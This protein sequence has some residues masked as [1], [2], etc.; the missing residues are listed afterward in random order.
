MTKK[1]IPQIGNN[2][3]IK[4]FDAST[5][6]LHRVIHVEGEIISQPICTD[7]ELYVTVKRGQHTSMKFYTVPN[8]SLKKTQS[9][10]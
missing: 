3:T 2:N 10:Q 5:G 9:L 4:L 6:Q 1:F 8:G 7:D